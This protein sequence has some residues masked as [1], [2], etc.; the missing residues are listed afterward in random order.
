MFAKM[1]TNLGDRLD[2]LRARYETLHAQALV[3]LEE[4]EFAQ[5]RLLMGAEQS[6]ALFSEIAA[7]TFE[8]ARLCDEAIYALFVDRVNPLI[9]RG[10]VKK[11]ERFAD[12]CE[13]ILAATAADKLKAQQLARAHF[14]GNQ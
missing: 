12:E 6:I 14:S 7:K 11:A 9:F 8:Q 2:S 4:A 3:E 1:R 13:A 10:S 5:R